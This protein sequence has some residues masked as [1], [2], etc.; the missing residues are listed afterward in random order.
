MGYFKAILS[1]I[2][3]KTTRILNANLSITVHPDGKK[4]ELKATSEEL[5]E[6]TKM[7][8]F[9]QKGLPGSAFKS[10]QTMN[11]GDP[12]PPAGLD[13]PIEIKPS[14][15]A[16]P[17]LYMPVTTREGKE[18]GVIEVFTKHS[19][20]PFTEED[21][22]MLSK[23]SREVAGVIDPSKRWTSCLPGL[24]LVG[25]VVL[26]TSI[27]HGLLP[28]NSGT[29]LG[30]V[31]IALS[32][33]LLINNCF[34][35]PIKMI[36]GVRFALRQ[37]LRTA[38][39]LLG[40]RLAFTQLITIGGKAVIMIV[41][42]ISAALVVSHFM[43]RLTKIPTRLA[44]LLG[45]GTAVCGNT[46]IAAIAPVINA[47]RE[48]FSFAIATNTL[49]GTIAVVVFPI[50]GRYLGYSDAFF[51]TWVGTAV[52]DTSQVIATGFSYSQ[53]AGEMATIIKLTRNSMM[54]FVLVAMGMLYARSPEN[55]AG[56]AK[57]S[58]K[59]RFI[60]SIPMFVVGFL[61]MA[62]LNTFG[63]FAWISNVINYDI[64]YF[65]KKVCKLLILGAMAGVGLGTSFA[66]MR[67]TGGG[68]IL[69]GIVTALTTA[70]LSLSLIY[71]LGPAGQ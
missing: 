20:K 58:L 37:M 35:I 5:D 23:L 15:N 67:K 4:E 7:S 27:I 32:L 43:G 22:S 48:E 46:A 16:R 30:D 34:I 45:V 51:G 10:E 13:S 28:G 9:A 50:I 68:P 11:R 1:D 18:L 31:L 8:V 65:I 2:A 14:L 40:C 70:L 12:H 26:F 36:P 55:Q 39:I 54:A 24:G 60:D 52:N 64:Q 59:K 66:Q 63:L 47:K 21:R 44:I 41:I 69:V 33:G 42:L 29:V 3:K 56:L 38:I 61:L 6:T 71:F 25:G 53:E 49:I 62:L 57:V 17:A 19:G